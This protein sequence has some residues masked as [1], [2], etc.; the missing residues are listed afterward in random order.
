MIRFVLSWSCVIFEK[1]SSLLDFV[2]LNDV[3]SVGGDLE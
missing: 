3:I 1:L 2:L